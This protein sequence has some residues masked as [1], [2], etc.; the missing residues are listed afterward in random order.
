VIGLILATIFA[1]H[2]AVPAQAQPT[3]AKQPPP[4]V[5]KVAKDDASRS[6]ERLFDGVPVA[7]HVPLMLKPTFAPGPAASLS[8][9]F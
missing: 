1:A 2:K 7:A 9:K 5:Q 3:V 6:L 4:I 8:L